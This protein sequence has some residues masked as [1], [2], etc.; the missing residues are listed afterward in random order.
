MSWRVV[1]LYCGTAKKPDEFPRLMGFIPLAENHLCKSLIRSPNRRNATHRG[2]TGELMSLMG[3][4][5]TNDRKPKSTVV[6][7][8]PKADK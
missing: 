6:R 3:Q 4:K 8:C 2:K 1:R 5:R 7:S